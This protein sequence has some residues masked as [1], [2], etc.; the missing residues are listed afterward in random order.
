MKEFR[1]EDQTQF[2][3]ILIQGV[4]SV[5]L[6][7]S[8]QILRDLNKISSEFQVVVQVC[9]VSKIATWE[10]IFFGCLYAMLAFKQ[11]RNLLN[12][13]PLEILL[14]ISGQR[15]IKNAIEEFG[16]KNGENCIIILGNEDE[17]M[18]QTLMRCEKLLGGEYSDEVLEIT[19]VSKQTEICNY[20]QI[21]QEDT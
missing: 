4:R 14:Y 17:S 16:I 20:F 21:S 2:K 19:D 7:D 11:K 15:Q 12:R 10:H 13:L 9:S 6:G 18:K 1:E 8:Q 3:S 5:Q